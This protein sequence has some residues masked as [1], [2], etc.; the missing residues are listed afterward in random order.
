[1]KKLSIAQYFIVDLA[2]AALHFLKDCAQANQCLIDELT[3]DQLRD[4]ATRK[5]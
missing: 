5:K 2:T 4:Y 1:M 3:E